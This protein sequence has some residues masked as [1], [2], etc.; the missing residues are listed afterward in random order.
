[1]RRTHFTLA[2][3][4]GFCLPMASAQSSTQGPVETDPLIDMSYDVPD[5]MLAEEL[6]PNAGPSPDWVNLMSYD[7]LGLTSGFKFGSW[8]QD[9]LVCMTGSSHNIVSARV[10]IPHKRK[11]TYFRL[12]GYDNS[13][14]GNLKATLWRNCLPDTAAGTPVMT[15]LATVSSTGAPGNFTTV[16]A[17]S[18]ALVVDAHVCTYWA[19]VEFTEC[20]DLPLQ[21]RKIHVEHTK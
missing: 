6:S 17:L 11:I 8:L 4:L 18:P 14:S 16:S 12:W 15:S 5:S 21:L 20:A 2:L 7:F 3:A 1:M 10:H 13:T 9:G 19:A